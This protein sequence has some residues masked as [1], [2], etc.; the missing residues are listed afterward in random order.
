MTRTNRFTLIATILGASMVFIDGTVVNVALPALQRDLGGGLAAQQWVV[1][2][3]LLT[4]GSLILVGGSIGDIF[5]ETRVF[6]LGVAA[7]GAASILCGIAPDINTLIVFRAIQGIAG[8]LL[9]PASLAL[10]TSTFSGEERGAAIGTW[11]AWTGISIVIGP[12]F[13]GWLIDVSSWRAI[14]FVNIPIAVATMAIA[15]RLP[16]GSGRTA[17][18]VDLVGAALCTFGLGALVFGFIEQPRRGWGDAAVA[19]TIAGG[20]ALLVAFVLYEARTREP[21]LPLRLFKSRNFTVTNIE[22]LA[23]YGALSG[24]F[25][26]LAIFL[27]QRAGWSPLQ[28]GA[29]TSPVT[30]VM[31]LFSRRVGALSA[32]FGPRFFMSAGPIVAGLSM[33]GLARLPE[34]VNYW[35]DVLPPLL[36]FSIGMTLTVA[37]LTTTVLSEAGPGDAGIASG[38]NNAVARVA[39]L[40]AIALL[41]IAAGGQLTTT[42]FHRTIAVA[43]AFLVVGGLVGAAGIRNPSSR[44]AGS[45]ET[46]A[47]ALPS[48][49]R[50]G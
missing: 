16:R 36:G 27:Q 5:G 10:I 4:L 23:V 7:F 49:S 6:M 14:F 47:S 30:V 26:F 44:S 48:P 46:R 1:D 45:P 12:L 42:G 32:R 37:P 2:A 24:A 38:V 29:A 28:A 15:L 22:T 39:G 40:L 13:G 11:T 34:H 19:G 35:T 50:R 8:A 21:M 3:Y 20:A 41:G 17:V 31:F 9:T 43:A 18:R 33:L 25:F